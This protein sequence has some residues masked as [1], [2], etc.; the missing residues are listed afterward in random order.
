MEK[1]KFISARLFKYMEFWKQGIEQSTTYA[2]KMCSDVNYWEDI[3]LHLSKPL[4]TQ[5]PLFWRVF[6][7]PTIGS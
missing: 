3:L 1:E 4:P 6:S 7:L 5:G 2:M